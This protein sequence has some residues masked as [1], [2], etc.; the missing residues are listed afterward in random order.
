MSEIENWGFN[1]ENETMKGYVLRALKEIERN[2]PKLALSEEQ[3][4]A[5]FNGLRWATSEMTAQE[6]YEYYCNN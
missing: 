4:N 2:E 3:K 1:C 6:A 5:L